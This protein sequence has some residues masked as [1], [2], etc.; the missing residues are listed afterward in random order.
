[1]QQGNITYEEILKET[2]IPRGSFAYWC[3]RAGVRPIGKPYQKPGFNHLMLD[4][5]A[6]SIQRIKKVYSASKARRAGRL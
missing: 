6:D 3:S 4:Y 1:M 2:G 5:P